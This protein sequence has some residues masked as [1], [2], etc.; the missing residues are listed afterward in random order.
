MGVAPRREAVV[1][2]VDGGVEEVGRD[3]RRAVRYQP[4]RLIG[5]AEQP[6]TGRDLAG[7]I[8]EAGAKGGVEL[9]VA[10][11]HREQRARRRR[12][13][14]RLLQRLRAAV[15]GEHGVEVLPGEWEHGESFR[16]AEIVHRA[17]PS[18]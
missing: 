5:I 6:L 15:R 7:Q 1:E 17:R 2:L 14:D 4:Q 18:P 8:G 16:S 13:L 11:D 12:A 9:D 3:L 10:T